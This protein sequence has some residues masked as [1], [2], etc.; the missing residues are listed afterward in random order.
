MGVGGKS[1]DYDIIEHKGRKCL[2]RKS[3]PIRGRP[4]EIGLRYRER[5]H[6]TVWFD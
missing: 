4:T 1:T 2:G 6:D 5:S 3:G